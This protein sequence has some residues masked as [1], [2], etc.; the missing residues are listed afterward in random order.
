MN[1]DRI[2]EAVSRGDK[3]M[4]WTPQEFLEL[5]TIATERGWGMTFMGIAHMIDVSNNHTTPQ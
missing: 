5:A 4:K 1:E 2:Y 3:S